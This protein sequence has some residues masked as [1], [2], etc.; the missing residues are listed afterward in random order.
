MT[1]R[2]VAFATAAGTSREVLSMLVRGTVGDGRA[3]SCWP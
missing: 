2:L 1:V 3:W